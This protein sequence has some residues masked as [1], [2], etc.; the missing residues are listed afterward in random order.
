MVYVSKKTGNLIDKPLQID[1]D[2]VI[3]KHEIYNQGYAARE[4][5]EPVTT[6]PWP[7]ASYASNV[8]SDGWDDYD[9]NER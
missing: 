8:W 7:L 1:P 6:N 5:G 2:K 3:D 4:A 9:M